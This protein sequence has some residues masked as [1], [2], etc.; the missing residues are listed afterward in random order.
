MSRNETTEIRVMRSAD[1]AAAMRL[2]QAAGWNQ[3][4]QDWLRFLALAPRGCFVGIRDGQVVATLTTC[5]LPPT[6]WIGMML[7]EPSHRRQG[8]ASALMRYAVTLLEAAGCACIRLDATSAG[9]AVYQQLGFLPEERIRR[10]WGVPRTAR[11]DHRPLLCRHF[12]WS[13][14]STMTA[15]DHAATGARRERLLKRLLLASPVPA[16]VTSEG[17]NLAGYALERPGSCARFLGPIVATNERVGNNLLAHVLWRNH[18]QTVILDVP[19]RQTR[20]QALAADAGLTVQREFVRMTR[21][22]LAGP[23]ST[24]VWATSGPEKG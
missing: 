17:G 22:T 8:I 9:V 4:R 2:K 13:D 16:C 18:R 3:T 6:A 12:R 15:L 11:A 5:V 10:F 24:W 21:G 1:I 20:A 14:W 7:V 23:A 19:D